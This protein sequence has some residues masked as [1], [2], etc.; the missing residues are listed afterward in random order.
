MYGA[1]HC[2]LNFLTC[3]CHC[4]CFLCV[5]LLLFPLHPLQNNEELQATYENFRELAAKR[6]RFS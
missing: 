4:H 3:H 6:Q 1:T 2:S 5:C